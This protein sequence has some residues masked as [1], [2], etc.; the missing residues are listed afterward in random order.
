MTP[1]GAIPAGRMDP[2]ALDPAR[3][4][5]RRARRERALPRVRGRL[6]GARAGLRA[7]APARP[8]RAPRGR[9]AAPARL[10]ARRGR[11]GARRRRGASAGTCDPRPRRAPSEPRRRARVRPRAAR[12]TS[13]ASVPRA[14][15]A[16][17]RRA[18]LRLGARARRGHAAARRSD[19]ASFELRVGDEPGIDGLVEALALAGYERVERVEE[20]GQFAV[21]GGIVDVFPS[22]GREPLRIELFGDE[23]EQIRAFSPFT[24]RAL[25]PRRRGRRL[26]G[27]RA[28]RRLVEPT[29]ERRGRGRR[30]RPTTSSPL[31]D[32]AP[33]LVWQLDDVRRVWEEEGLAAARRSTARRELDPLPAVAAAR[34][35]GAASRD[36]RARPRRGRERARGDRPR[37]D[38]ASSSRSRTAAR[39]C[40]TQRAAAQ[41][42]GRRRSSRA[43]TLGAEPVAR[44]SSSSPA[45]RGFVWRDLGL[46]LLPDTQ[47]FRKRPPRAD[48]R[49]GR[50]LAVVR[51]PAGR[52]LR[53]PR[54][55]RRREAPRL[56][57]E[58][59]RGRHA[60]LPLPRV[61]GR[62]PALRPARADRRRSRRYIGADATAPALSKL[63]GK[64]WQNLKSARARVGARA[65]GRAARALRAAPAGA[66]GV[67]LRPHE[68]LARA[69]R[70]V[71]PVPRDRRPAAGDR[72]R[73]GGSRVGAADGPA[74]LRRRRL[75]QDRGRG[76]GGVRRRAST[77]GRRSSSARRRSSPSSTGT[78]SASAT[79]TSRC[80]SRWCRAS[81]AAPT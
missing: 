35:R 72:G 49:L 52:R 41:G 22:T 46:A 21:R 34:L 24:Q 81:A 17:A 2:T 68:R 63:G 18:R 31:V 3:R 51:R 13:S 20:R 8:R 58:G 47:V 5:R 73:E 45:R 33:D 43:T 56:R 26:P 55:P 57:D 14:R 39:R 44:A 25:H 54:G 30:A 7:G 75:R 78:P 60:R 1:R 6:P 64:A 29:L 23:I 16:R 77:A 40:G 67:A 9:S 50:A 15:R 70:G 61:P 74:R 71:V 11:G 42:R 65:R 19:P 10:P 80:A 69:A 76:A 27:A 48:A 36:R 62:G 38:A 53:R 66:E 37:R 12:R 4:V 32:R 28:T 59:G 79:A